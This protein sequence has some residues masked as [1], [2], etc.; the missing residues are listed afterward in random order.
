MRL[1]R[2]FV[3]ALGLVLVLAQRALAQPLADRVPADALFYA[4]WAGAE[5]LGPAY[6]QSHLKGLMDA[7]SMPQLL[8]ELGPRIVRRIQ[9]EQMLQG[10]PAAKDLLPTL[11]ALGESAWKN[12]TALYFGP[13]D[14]S[15][16]MPTPKVAILCQA[17]KEAQGLA[18][19]LTKVVAQLPP[20]VPVK[21]KVAVWPGDVVVVSTFEMSAPRP[22]D[23]L[24]QREQFVSAVKQGRADPALIAFFDSEKVLN[25]ASLAINMAA[26]AKG[27]Q[28]W[29]RALLT[30]GM[31]GIK[32]LVVTAGFDGKDWGTQ[33]F[34][35]A[36]QPR[37][38]L[39]ASLLDSQPVSDDLLKRAPQSSNWVAASRVDLAKMMADLRNT[40]ARL[41]PEASKEVEG[42]LGQINTAVGFDLQKDFLASMGDQWMAFNS[43]ETGHGLF[44]M[45]L[46]NPLRNAAK[47]EKAL[48]AL[49]KHANE[50]MAQDA[51]ENGPTI[52][53]ETTKVGD[54]TIHYLAVPAVAP[55]WAIKND[56]LYV[57]LF[58][59]ILSAAAD[60]KAEA[61]SSILANEK[62]KAAR[63]RLGV[64]ASAISFSYMDLPK[65]APRGYQMVLALQRG[66]LG[67]A[68]MFGMQTPAMVVP[69]LNK[70][71]P[72][73]G[74]S[75]SATWVDD[76][77]WHYR[78]VSPF[79]GA[80]VLG[81]EQAVAVTAA[82]LAAAVLV[83]A[84]AR[85]RQQ[86]VM[87]QGM[88]NMRQIG[89]GAIMY[90]NDTKG[91]LPPD[92]GSTLRYVQSPLAYV[93][94]AH[95]G[96][97]M[98][99]ATAKPEE[100]AKWVNENTD[101]VYLGKGM[102]KMA[103]IPNTA[104]TILA[105][106]KFELARN[107]GVNVLYVDGHV[108]WLPVPLAKQRVDEQNKARAAQ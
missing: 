80:D 15:G 55:C 73:L 83:P 35:E 96:K 100:L 30:T 17:G 84:S 52:A 60:V 72:H 91:E 46:I 21:V 8:S 63:E 103:A 13:L 70:I 6:A 97:M 5:K 37:M 47:L 87:V 90:A 36:P 81:G 76:A 31:A 101:Y 77:G 19:N 9:L 22:E 18:D 45:T 4:G 61:G 105:Y 89:M 107:G 10:D 53:F 20:D 78:G 33:A 64:S 74:T 79:P 99:P 71:M 68:D 32:R 34:I 92:L 41:Q 66:A 12:P 43:D 24:A 11:L 62:F 106:E 28:M 95:V 65:L 49:E 86:A 42:M 51:G 7:S 108:E 75:F 94:P 82:P 25:V 67:F 58:P 54:M 14:Y 3:V 2:T 40:V 38:G 57:A 29:Q 98:V 23:S 102:G 85:A 93:S 39:L 48:L 69:P 44:G 104:Q 59:Q 56:T 50:A 26:D 1:V 16:K 27:K 88:S